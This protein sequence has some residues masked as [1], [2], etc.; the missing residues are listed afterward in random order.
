[1]AQVTLNKDSWHFKYY[2][3][4]VSDTPPKSLC[5]YFWTM[6]L[7]MIISPVIGVALAFIYVHKNVTSF[8]DSIVP[9]KERKHETREEIA[10]RWNKEAEQEMKRIKFWNKAGNYFLSFLKFVVL[11]ILLIALIYGVY[12]AGVKMGWLK[13]IIQVIGGAIGALLLFG[14][15]FTIDWLVNKIKSPSS[16]MRNLNP[17]NW[18]ATKIVGEMIKAQYTKMCPLITWEGKDD[19]DEEYTVD[20]Q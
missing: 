11:P 5:P 6:V 3:M 18:K 13:L 2:S 17:F 1:M 10:I 12:Q 4:I 15:F 9:K 8:F 20:I 7:L 14:V 19:N 16:F